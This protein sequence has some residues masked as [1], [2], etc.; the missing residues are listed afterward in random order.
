MTDIR[1][2]HLLKTPE[3]EALP[4]IAL[5]AFQ[6][7]KNVLIKAGDDEMAEALNDALWTFRA[8]VFLPH[9]SKADGYGPQQPVWVTAGDDVPNNAKIQIAAAGA[10][11]LAPSG[12]D[13]C[14]LMLDGRDEAQVALA[15]TRWKAFKDAGHD[16]SY[17][18]QTEQGW[19]KKA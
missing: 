16:I 6:S 7:G 15:R 18:Q 8:D 17:W 1:F 4:Q 3:L 10:E 19:E 9:G 11:P 14:C 5:K 13:L 12:F 2:Y